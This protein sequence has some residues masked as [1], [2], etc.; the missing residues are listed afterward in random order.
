MLIGKTLK[1][2]IWAVSAIF[3]YHWAV[4]KKYEKPEQALLVSQP[5]LDAARKV[6]WFFFDI[7]QLLTKP[8]MSKMLP[9]R[10]NIPGMPQPKTL[11]LNFNGT[12]VHQTYQ[13]G[14]GVELYKRPGLTAF[15]NRLAQKYEIVVFGVGEMGT[16][17]EAC[18]AMDPNQQIF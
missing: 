12:M 8:G 7:R 1:Y 13:L 4:I 10:L 16:I 2:V 18:Q 6:D 15:L 5:F 9:D 3:F 11:V 17:M 14:V